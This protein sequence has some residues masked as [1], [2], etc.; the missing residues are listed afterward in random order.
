M[1]TFT[2]DFDAGSNGASILAAD[3]GSGDVFDSRTVTAGAT[4]TYSN[5]HPH[6]GTLAARHVTTSGTAQDSELT[7]ST[8]IGTQTLTYFRIY[9]WM[10]VFPGVG[11]TLF[12]ARSSGSLRARVSMSATGKLQMVNSAGTTLHTF[13][14]SLAVGQWVR[15]EGKLDHTGDT[16]EVK[17]FN[18]ASLLTPSETY[19]ASAATIG[20]SANSFEFGRVGEVNTAYTFE[21]DDYGLSTTA[22]LGPTAIPV[23]ATVGEDAQFVRMGVYSSSDASWNSS[24]A[25]TTD[26]RWD[27]PARRWFSDMS[28]NLV[29]MKANIDAADKTLTINL[30]SRSGSTTHPW[31]EITA[32]TWDSEIIA[33]FTAL[34]LFASQDIYV[35][36]VDEPDG[37]G[38]GL[39]Q[40]AA[41]YF[42]AFDHVKAIK[43]T[44]APRVFLGLSLAMASRMATWWHSAYEWISWNPYNRQHTNATWTTFQDILD[45][46]YGF[47]TGYAR[48]VHMTTG[49][50]ENDDDANGLHSKRQWMIDMGLVLQGFSTNYPEIDLIYYWDSG[51]ASGDFSIDTTADSLEGWNLLVTEDYTTVLAPVD[52]VVA[53]AQPLGKV[54]TAGGAVAV[55]V[56]VPRPTVDAGNANPTPVADAVAAGVGTPTVRV[57]TGGTATAATAGVGQ[58][59]VTATAHTSPSAVGVSVGVLTPSVICD[60]GNTT[61]HPAS[62][63]V[64][65][66]VAQ[67]LAKLAAKPEGLDVTVGLDSPEVS[68]I[69]RATPIPGEVGLRI[70]IPAPRV[71]VVEQTPG[72]ILISWGGDGS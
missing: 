55:S 4:L 30:P 21:T 29:T 26:V 57:T 19:S 9:V 22:Y 70:T 39:G 27:I 71:T 23:D 40:S 42:D 43:T 62:V 46:D 35:S 34:N 16:F 31:T 8:S 58:P 72:R 41:T 59:V 56:G 67:A 18:N 5:A 60:V 24:I 2:H 32:G 38:N 1:T 53:V 37:T 47:M 13:A 6:S 61:A 68:G 33:W 54:A 12:R 10:D 51:D 52:A 49:S 25:L 50:V 14:A 7:W 15:I 20:A 69:G 65:V 3:A 28:N 45:R 66:A 48:P 17:L 63:G 64:T 11:I 44:Y 36:F